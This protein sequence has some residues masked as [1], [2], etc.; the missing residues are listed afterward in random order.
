[1]WS[2]SSSQGSQTVHPTEEGNRERCVIVSKRKIL[3]SRLKPVIFENEKGPAGFPGLIRFIDGS[4]A[5]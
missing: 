4:L 5:G 3:Q 1:M 2:V